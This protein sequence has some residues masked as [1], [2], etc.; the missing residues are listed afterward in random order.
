LSLDEA[1]QRAL[2]RNPT[3]ETAREEIRRAQA[4]V[5]QARAQSIPTLTATGAYNR[6]E[7]IA[8][9]ME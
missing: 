8:S 9:R 5:W 6:L 3:Y 1:V 2:A 4:L 7:A